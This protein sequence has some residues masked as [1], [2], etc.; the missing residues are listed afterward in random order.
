MLW[1][2]GLPHTVTAL[3]VMDHQARGYKAVMVALG[4]KEVRIYRD[5]FLV[6]VLKLAVSL[7]VV[8]L[9]AFNRVLQLCLS[10]R[11]LWSVCDSAVTGARVAAY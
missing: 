4:N 6:N 5:Q 9:E 11:T 7:S 2:V 1:S 8:C 10:H 3:D